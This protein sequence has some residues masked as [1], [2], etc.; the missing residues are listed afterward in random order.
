MAL[1]L[2]RTVVVLGVV[3]FFN[4]L[5][6]EI[7]VPLI[8][9]LL[10]GVLAAGPIALGLVEGVADAVASF[11]KL[12]SGRHSDLLG[13]RRKGL[14]LAGYTLSNVARP[15][16]GLAGS[17]GG[18]LLLRSIDRVGKGLR[19]APRDA[20]V[21]D[22]TPAQLRGYAYGFHRALDNAGAVGGSLL[23]AAVLAWSAVSLP[24][25]ILLSAIPGFLAV[26]C[27]AVGVKSP[28]PRGAAPLPGQAAD[29]VPRLAWTLLGA[30]IR[31][32]LT[33]V[34]LFT[35]ARA[36]ETFILLL[37][38]ERGAPTV[39]LLLLWATLSFS[40]AVTA[41]LG[42]RLS[43]RFGRGALI[44]ASWSAFALS[45]ALFGAARG[46]LALWLVTVLY[47]LLT[48]AGE[49]AERAVVADFARP[50]ERG[51]AFG[52]YNLVAGLAAIPAGLLFGTLWQYAGAAVAFN[53]A[54]AVAAVAALLLAA[55]AWPHESDVERRSA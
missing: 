19:T 27:L 8:P 5:A 18:V 12:W 21:S 55:W 41:T 44:V 53:A 20:L 49:G 26:L 40:K 10:A 54:A 32:Y 38:H 51:T 2:P 11:I 31:R 4:D 34:A 6:S 43:D 52:W 17:W 48:G 46:P 22:A 45:F 47:G 13:G 36:S 9:I 29:A 7:V 25:M 33:V 39:E 50:A 30:P 1:K 14:T 23:A 37:G 16:L 15:L 24:Q 35:L 3:S 42:G 28:A